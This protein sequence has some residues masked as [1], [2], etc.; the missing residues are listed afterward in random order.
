MAQESKFNKKIKYM[1]LLERIG[2]CI[3]TNFD[4]GHEK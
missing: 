4:F 2:R 1:I 3:V